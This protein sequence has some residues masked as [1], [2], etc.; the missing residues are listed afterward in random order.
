M[1]GELWDGLYSLVM[2][3]ASRRGRRPRVQHSDARIVLVFLW[4]ALHDRPVSWACDRRHWPAEHRWPLPSAPT[5]SRRMR[6]VGTLLLLEG[7]LQS[8]RSSESGLCRRM[9]SKPLPVGG[10]SKARD[11][12]RGHATGGMAK[13]Y[14]LYCVWGRGPTPDLWRIDPLNRP[15]AAIAGELIPRLEGTG[16]L[17]ADAVHEGNPLAQQAGALGFQLV[18]PRR[19]PGRGLG[20]HPCGSWRLRSIEL[21]EGPSPFGRSLCR[22]RGLIEREYGHLTSFACGLHPLPA[23]VRRPHR[24]AAWVAAKLLINAM[25]ILR[26]RGQMPK[27][28]R[29]TAPPAA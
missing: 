16:Y 23:W 13:G 6:S 9:D 11:A 21:T 3:E 12:R 19:K 17:L 5:M 1:E 22:D 15:D 4:A 29:P 18:S 7:L 2:A 27:R 26:K 8:L 25:R 10:F 14:K 20:H 28:L 24:V